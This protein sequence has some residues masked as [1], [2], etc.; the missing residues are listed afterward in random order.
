MS[1]TTVDFRNPMALRQAGMDALRQA[2]GVVGT[3][4]FLRQL[5]PGKG[6]YTAERDSILGD[7]T[8]EDIVE[9]ILAMQNARKAQEAQN[10]KDAV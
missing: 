2:L 4:Y 10:V 7:L 8:N 3:T 5:N 1:N 9:G 6:D